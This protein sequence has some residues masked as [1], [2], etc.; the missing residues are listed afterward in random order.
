VIHLAKR[1]TKLVTGLATALL[2]A[3]TLAPP[4]TAAAEEPLIARGNEPSFIIT[5]GEDEVVLQMP[6]DGITFR[7]SNVTRS[8]VDGHPRIEVSA[9]GNTLQVTIEQRL[10]AD[11][12][13][14]MPF[15]VAVRADFNGRR[16]D[17]CGGSTFTAIEGG[18]R[19]LALEGKP[20]PDGVIATIA[21]EAPD[22][23]S[24]KT[25]CNRYFGAF[26]LDAESLA[27]GPLGATRMICPKDEM[28]AEKLFLDLAARVTRAT[29]GENGRMKLMA[30][31]DEAMLLDRVD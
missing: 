14:G 18:W 5:I 31:D 24:G 8:T 19:V 12:M 30:G 27:I 13:T 25:G 17:G 4:T 21:F 16:L 15:P 1:V 23:V 11:S 29:P 2:I 20:L 7:S 3:A 9:G 22:R 26:R 6:L 10:C 28:A